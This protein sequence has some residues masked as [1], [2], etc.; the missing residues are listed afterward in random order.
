MKYEKEKQSGVNKEGGCQL[1]CSPPEGPWLWF[2]L[3]SAYKGLYGR[4]ALKSTPVVLEAE[5]ENTYLYL[6]N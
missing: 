2:D 1:Y 5:F 6:N 4:I 3:S